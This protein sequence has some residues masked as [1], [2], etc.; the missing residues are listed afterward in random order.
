M[1]KW[2]G[3]DCLPGGS[4]LD[5]RTDSLAAAE[6]AERPVADLK[7][8]PMRKFRPGDILDAERR[9]GRRRVGWHGNSIQSAAQFQ[10]RGLHSLKPGQSHL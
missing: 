4:S 5:R 1:W 8:F 2:K 7:A 10:R 9:T 3:D 6:I